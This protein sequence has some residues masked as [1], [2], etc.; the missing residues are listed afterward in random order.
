MI[1]S[2]GESLPLSMMNLMKQ[3]HPKRRAF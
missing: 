3:L 2:K 1:T